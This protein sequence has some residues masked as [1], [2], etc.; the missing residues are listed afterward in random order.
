MTLTL[1]TAPALALGS[2][3][4]SVPHGGW[5]DGPLGVMAALGVLRAWAQSGERPPRTLALVDWADEE[6]AFG[7]SL[8]GSSAASGSLASDEVASLRAADGRQI[9][10]SDTV[11]N[12]I[13]QL[14]LSFSDELQR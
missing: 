8:L 13:G 3:L 9:E 11:R 12:E 4:D 6:G 2:H 14:R 10:E 1:S 5:L 7:R